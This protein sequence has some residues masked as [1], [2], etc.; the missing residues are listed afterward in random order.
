M[1]DLD[2]TE[3]RLEALEVKTAF[4]DDLL[5]RLNDV[6]SRQQGQIERLHTELRRLQEQ[7][8]ATPGGGLRSLLD[9]KPPHW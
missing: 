3:R 8:D 2:D 5:D 6:V 7:L 4:M 9:E 1:P